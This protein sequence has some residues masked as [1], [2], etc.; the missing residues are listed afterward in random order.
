[1]QQEGTGPKPPQG[2]LQ[3]TAASPFTTF[4]PDAARS[5]LQAQESQADFQEAAARQGDAANFDATA[6]IGG[7]SAQKLPF[8]AGA[9]SKS[10]RPSA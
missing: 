7:G 8:A 2:W 5:M 1:M 10:T 4:M 3:P 9:S 6:C